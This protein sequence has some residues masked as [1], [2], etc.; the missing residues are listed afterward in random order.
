MDNDK[1][2]IMEEVNKKLAELTEMEQMESFLKS[3]VN[4]F[5]YKENTYRVHK[6]TSVEKDLI[7]KERMKKYVEY[8]KD[9]IYMFRKQLI[10]LL[11]SKG[12]DIV[13]MEQDSRQAYLQEKDMLRRLAKTDIATDIE[14][15]KLR[16]NELRDQQDQLFV[17]KEELLKYCIEKQLED[18][19]RFYVLY[20]VLEVKNGD[21]WDKVY[22]SYE[23][24]QNSDDNLLLGRAAQVLA[25]IVYNESL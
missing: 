19:V 7:N 6:P 12:V 3:N 4:E 18:F 14:T 24:F 22:K 25:A 15:L 21:I 11:K 16:I 8:L 23:D 17:E 13:R 1:E 9:P 10:D 2:V 20:V 5:L